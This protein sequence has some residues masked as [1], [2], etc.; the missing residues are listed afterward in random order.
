MKRCHLYPNVDKCL[1]MFKKELTSLTRLNGSTAKLSNFDPKLV[2]L[3]QLDVSVKNKMF[4][5][6][7]LH[8]PVCYIPFLQSSSCRSPH[9]H[10]AIENSSLCYRGAGCCQRTRRP[11]EAPPASPTGPERLRHLRCLCLRLC[12]GVSW[13]LTLFVSSRPQRSISSRSEP[14]KTDSGV[15]KNRFFYCESIPLL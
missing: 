1:P 14:V 12:A 7:F 13:C 9:N 10:L 4:Q 15:D 6:L 5:K 8:T 2:K 3:S 11:H